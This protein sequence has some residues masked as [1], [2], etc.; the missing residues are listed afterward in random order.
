MLLIK[1]QKWHFLSIISNHFF[2]DISDI[3][4]G[5]NLARAWSHTL[6]EAWLV[7][8]WFESDLL[9][10]VKFFWPVVSQYNFN[11]SFLAQI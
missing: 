2:A 5:L 11:R 10:D 9:G 7:S 4:G 3:L 8:A 1:Q 6:F